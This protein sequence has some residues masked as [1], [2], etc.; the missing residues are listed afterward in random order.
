[1]ICTLMNLKKYLTHTAPVLLCLSLIGNTLLMVSC[2]DDE[3]RL[4]PLPYQVLDSIYSTTTISFDEALSAMIEEFGIS[5]EQID[6]HRQQAKLASMRSRRYNAH[7]VTYHTTDP[8]GQPVLASGVIYFPKSGKPLGVIEAISLNKNKYECPSKHL[9]NIGLMQ[10]MSGYIVI[11]SDQIGS[12]ATESMLFPYLNNDNIAKV[13]ADLRVAATELV[14]N[15]YGCSMP[16]W[17]LISGFSLA[18]SGAWALARYYHLHPELG[19]KV[20][21]IW[22]SGGAYRPMLVL[23]HQLQTLYADYAFIP[24]C[25]YSVNYYDHLGLNLQEAFRGELREHYEEWCTGYVPLAD[26]SLLLGPDISQYLNLDFFND[27]NAD[28]Q[29]LCA[30]I[31]RLGIPNDWVPTCPV[32]IY[33]GSEDTYVPIASS[34]ELANYLQSV[35]ADVDYVV[36]ETD[37]WNNGILMGADLAKY[38]YK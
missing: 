32:H 5:E 14:R 3:E 16:S 11:M 37:H 12:G 29:R 31:E 36:T 22:M 20:N 23:K 38:L 24:N 7:V 33:H 34:D 30:S 2:E 4:E 10:G 27:D 21:Q 25:L 17:T 6:P 35:G 18:A 19:V 1:M 26:L 13:S 9:A 8:H 28:Y 15:I